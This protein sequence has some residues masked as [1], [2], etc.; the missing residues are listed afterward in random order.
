MFVCFASM[1]RI[2]KPIGL[3]GVFSPE[4]VSVCVRVVLLCLWAELPP[5]SCRFGNNWNVCTGRAKLNV[6]YLMEYL[7]TIIMHSMPNNRTIHFEMFAELVGI[8]IMQF[9]LV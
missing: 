5:K 7:C 1:F 4:Y 6:Y 9:E 2:V 8:Y 3:D